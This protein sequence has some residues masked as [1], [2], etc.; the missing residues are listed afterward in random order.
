[1]EVRWRAR[2]MPHGAPARSRQLILFL[3][4]KFRVHIRI[5]GK[6]NRFA[7]LVA[8]VCEHRCPTR[9][10]AHMPAIRARLGSGAVQSE[11]DITEAAE[12]GYRDAAD[13]GGAGV[14][15]DVGLIAPK[16]GR[17]HPSQFGA[18]KSACASSGHSRSM[19]PSKQKARS[20]SPGA[21]IS[22]FYFLNVIALPPPRRGPGHPQ[23]PRP[24]NSNF[25]LPLGHSCGVDLAD[26]LLPTP[27]QRAY[28]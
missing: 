22:R 7:A 23:T 12:I 9:K 20:R 11:C 21:K 14:A 27:S 4:S 28:S 6:L 18:P 8:D 17:K 2:S 26:P 10:D 15:G 19:G 16:T 5:I 3:R 13:D 1:M 25:L 24:S